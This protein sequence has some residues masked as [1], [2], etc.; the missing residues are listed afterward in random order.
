MDNLEDY[1]SSGI[2]ELYVYGV[3]SDK[4]NAEVYEA[5]KEYPEVA[6]EIDE[7]EKS[8]LKLSAAAAPHNPISLFDKIRKKL[9]TEEKDK[10]VVSLPKRT[11]WS[12]YIGWAA[13]VVLFVGLLIQFNKN[14]TLE[15][16]I[17]DS[18]VEQ[19]LLKGK[20]ELVEEDLSDTKNLLN[21]IR[22]KEL[23]RIPLQAQKIDPN[24]YATVYWDKEKEVTYID[25]DGL[26][27]PP[28]GKV[29]QVWSLTLNPLTPTS[30]GVLDSYKTEGTNIFALN[31]ANQSEAFGI[32]LEPEGGSES[33][34]L[35]Q[36]YTLGLVES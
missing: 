1:I 8:L 25:V 16:Q 14:K 20:I 12:A 11:N 22:D 33:P 7:I 19:E 31:N 24:A 5:S 2:L 6:K 32:T 26:P 29:Y 23:L 10:A 3:L 4:E 34:T 28:P 15:Q 13:A 27:T 17:V 18:N 21:I 35:E 30:L 9:N 36:L